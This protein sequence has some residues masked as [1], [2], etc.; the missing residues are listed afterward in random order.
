MS[1]LVLKVKA[2]SEKK[3]MGISEK[4]LK[5]EAPQKWC[6]IKIKSTSLEISLSKTLNRYITVPFL[7]QGTTLFVFCFFFGTTRNF[8]WND[9]ENRFFCMGSPDM[10]PVVLF[11]FFF[12]MQG[13]WVT[14]TFKEKCLMSYK[15]SITKGIL[16]IPK[17][18]L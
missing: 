14:R 3:F 9:K 10:S 4:S 5:S 2:Y 16:L 1:W 18:F 8:S 17:V 13:K 11:H 12:F 6:Q 7:E 15:K